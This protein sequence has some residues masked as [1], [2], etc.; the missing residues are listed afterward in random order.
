MSRSHQDANSIGANLRVG[1][2]L[3]T[4]IPTAQQEKKV[5]WL[6]VNSCSA[7]PLSLPLRLTTHGTCPEPALSLRPTQ[8]S[9]R[10]GE[11]RPRVRFKKKAAINPGFLP[12]YDRETQTRGTKKRARWQTHLIIILC[13]AAQQFICI[14]GSI[15]HWLGGARSQCCQL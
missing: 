5:P 3:I 15:M 13:S 9:N 2:R 1:K 14:T 4:A 11:G 10:A 6:Q 12:H 8:H 7:K